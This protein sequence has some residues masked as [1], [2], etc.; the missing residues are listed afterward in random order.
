[1]E[2][3]KTSTVNENE[4]VREIVASL[5]K[6]A[7]SAAEFAALRKSVCESPLAQK[8]LKD[9]VSEYESK[10]P[11]QRYF[12]AMF[13]LGRFGEISRK[14]DSSSGS[15]QT[16]NYI[17]AHVLYRT[18]RY[19]EAADLYEKLIGKMGAST[20]FEAK[21]ERL[22]CLLHYVDR[23]ELSQVEKAI[24]ELRKED[25]DSP[26]PRYLDAW[27]LERKGDF[28]KALDAYAQ[29]LV[30]HPNHT[31]TLFRDAFLL[32]LCG[33]DEEAI[34]M[35]E[36]LCRHAP[37]FTGA[38][39][40]LGT[41][42]EDTGRWDDAKRLYASILREHPN[43]PW[44]SRF[45]KD[46]QAS[47]HEVFDEEMSAREDKLEKI[48]RIP[49]TDFELSVR[50]RN[51]LHKMKIESLGDLIRKTE[52]DLL[53]FKNFGET[54]LT[55]I[56]AILQAKGL[57]LGQR[58]EEEERR[59]RQET[60]DMLAKTGNADIYNRSIDDL[61][62]GVRSRK[63]MEK[64]GIKTIGDLMARS[65]SELLGLRNFG[66]T[67]LKEVKIKLTEHGLKLKEM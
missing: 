36:R 22:E 38:L 15:S 27:I 63:V 53:S 66:A 56:K 46:A 34:R 64:L 11:D 65:E 30:F 40:N 62:L 48:L 35:Y 20:Q 33:F 43:H 23:E 26:H 25:S 2:S 10:K 5:G 28:E 57:R 32:D 50:S 14:L 3:T 9:V 55:E 51:C 42:Y 58:K 60:R 67:S 59:V 18:G 21:V 29:I 45:F 41:L 12:V 49:V 24:K 6:E 17:R 7:I 37:T 1:M 39:M 4:R 13:G 61:N 54:S 31:R 16:M 47:V 8:K 19:R 44:A 52:A